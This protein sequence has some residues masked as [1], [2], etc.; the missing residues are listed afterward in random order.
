MRAT[1]RKPGKVKIQPPMTPMIDVI[2]QL[3]IFFMLMPTQTSEGYLTTNLPRNEGPN[4]KPQI[5]DRDRIKIELVEEGA[6]NQ[7]VTIVLN[8]TLVL[9]SSF[10]DLEAALKG[11][12]AQGLP[13]DYP[14]LIAP[15]M[16]VRHKWV[17]RA[18]DAAVLSRFT[19][20]QFAV[21]G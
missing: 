20:I 8:D 5:I 1:S 2:F 16:A 11:Y 15:G 17:V 19:N 21:P 4:P 7:S 10:D 14:V 12:R 6:E 9:G 18:F 3:L 13:P